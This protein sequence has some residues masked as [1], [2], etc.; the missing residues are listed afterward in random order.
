MQSNPMR[1]TYSWLA[2]GSEDGTVRLT[3]F[4]FISFLGKLYFSNYH[5]IIMSSDTS[6][7]MLCIFLV[8]LVWAVSRS[9]DHLEA[10][11]SLHPHHHSST[12]I[13]FLVLTSRLSNISK[14]TSIVKSIQLD[15]ISNSPDRAWGRVGRL[16]KFALACIEYRPVKGYIP[17][18]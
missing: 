2:T 9:R 16:T 11:V 7:L 13:S 1:S 4:V 5:L 3:R 8:I 14:L 6:H 18:N 17:V 12:S 15:L 10:F